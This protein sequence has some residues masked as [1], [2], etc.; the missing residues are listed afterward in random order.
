M[1]ALFEIL[2]QL[3]KREDSYEIYIPEKWNYINS[4]CVRDP[5]RPGE[6]KVRPA[7][8]FADCVST[9]I[10]MPDCERS[11]SAADCVVYSML[12]RLF[13]A[14]RHNG[15]GEIQT[16]TFLK[17]LCLLP[18]LKELGVNT[19]YLLPFY[20]TGSRYQKGELASPYSIRDIM[21]I[22][23]AL[24]DELLS[25]MSVETEFKAFVEACHHLGL[26]V[27]ADFVF[28]TVSRDSKLIEEHP[29]WF[30][31]IKSDR[32][33]SF[34]PPQLPQVGHTV[35]TRE[36]AELLYKSEG[37]T[38]YISCFTF[39]PE[40]E[41]WEKL[42]REARACGRE[43]TEYTEE[44][45]SKT[46]MPGFADTLNDPQ[47]PWTDVT[48]PKFYFDLTPAAKTAAKAG[49]PPFV[50]QDGVKCSVVPCECPNTELW[51]YV[52]EVIPRYI[53]DYDIDGARIDMAHALPEHLNRELIQGIKDCDPD[54]LLWS[55]EFF[56]VNGGKAKREGYSFIT[57]GIWDLW[58]LTG[59][60][61]FNERLKENLLSALPAAAALE[62]ADTPRSAYLL[63][64]GAW[65]CMLY[66][67]ALL[68]NTVLMVNNG[69]ELGDI[70]PMNLGLK[71]TAEGQFVLP[72]E[73]PLYGKLAF[74]DKSYLNWCGA[75]DVFNSVK[76]AGAMR[77]HFESLLSDPECSWALLG[78][79]DD[80]T[81][82][83]AQNKAKAMLAVFNRGSGAKNLKWKEWLGGTDID[84]EKLR[85]IMKKNAQE[86]LIK[87]NGIIIAETEV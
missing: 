40:K 58:D 20:E 36:R 10:S 69:Q 8:F 55:E 68:P 28:R 37:I 48:F 22:D 71:N 9:V 72:P 78:E 29:D 3:E 24:H 44:K 76:S 15:D 60:K 16:G 25:G 35:I 70:Q 52:K 45:L 11:R 32:A 86:D 39:P 19:V 85:I 2:K 47:P 83:R 42:K 18:L 26:N 50:A 5:K 54:F 34:S 6:V 23:P 1:K 56:A 62:M 17:S 4:D 65:E 27:M 49:D 51:N 81:V 66:L 82:I 74:F 13:S 87:T 79:E 7:H 73:H 57:G 63:K 84:F 61:T 14:W 46:I 43:L 12:P 75:E 38:D 30:Y 59:D 67:N 31:W 64:A 21:K 77:L 41:E 80:L 33:Q 53:Q